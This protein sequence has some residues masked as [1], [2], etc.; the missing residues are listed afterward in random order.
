[1]A[2]YT[3]GRQKNLKVGLTSYSENKTSLEVVGKVGIGTTNATSSLYVVG[4]QFVTGV[5]TAS[6]FSGTATTATTAGS[7]KT[8]TDVIGGI[9]SVS[10]LFV[11]DIGISTLGTIKISS[12]II[13]ST[14]GTAATFFGN[15][16]GT[17]SSAGFAFTAFSLDSTA[18][19][20]ISVAYASTA[21]IATFAEKSGIS[22]HVI[23][24]IASVTQLNVTGI[25]TLGIVTSG[26][27]FS[28]GVVTATKFVGSLQGNADSATSATSAGSAG[29][30]ANATNLTGGGTASA[31]SLTINGNSTIS[32]ISTFGTGIKIDGTAGIITSINPG[33][34][35]VTYYGTLIGTAQ[36]DVTNV[37]NT[38]N[39]IGGIASVT[40]LFV[41]GIS[42]VGILTASRIG[43]GT[44]NPTTELWVGGNV[45]VTGISTFNN[46]RISSGIVS[47]TT[48]TAVTFFGDFVG[49]A[50]SAG[51]AQTAFTLNNRTESQFNVAYASTAGIATFATKSGVATDVI[52]GIASVTSLAVDLTGI[53]TLG[54]VKISSGIV[55]STTGTAVTFFGTFVGTASSA[56][57]AQT[58]FNLDSSASANIRVGFATTASNVIGG[59]ASVTDL[60]VSGFSTVGVLTA[61]MIGIGTT[62][63][64]AEL[65]VIGNSSISGIVTVGVGSTGIKID[66]TTGIITSSGVTTVTYFGNLTGTAS[67]ASFAQTAAT[68]GGNSVGDLRVGF[69]TTASNVVGGIASVTSLSVSGFSTVGVLTATRIGIGT[70][71][72]TAELFVFGNSVFDGTGIV[73][74]SKYNGDL[75]FG[76]P[77]APGFK[78][79]PVAITSTSSTRDSVN[80]INFILG[81]LVPKPPTTIAGVAL[82]VNTNAGTAL[83]C[84]SFTPVN[85]ATT[86]IVVPSAG[87][88]YKRN[89]SNTVSSATLTQY[90]P[91]DS[92]TV[93]ALLNNTV[94]VGTTT[95]STGSNNGTYG[96]LVISNDKDA[97]FSTRNTGI[98]S[99]FY[100]IYDAQISN[101]SGCPDG[102]NCISIRQ[103]TNETSKTT[104]LV[105]IWYEDG[106]TVSAP[107]L[108]AG[109]IV[110][111]STSNHQ[112]LYSSGVPHYSEDSA[113][114]FTYVLT[115]QN[116]SGDMYTSNTFCNGGSATSGFQASGNKTYTNFAGGTNPPA[117]NYGVGTGVTTLISQTPQ[118]TH[119]QLVSP[120]SFS[121]YTASTPYGTSSTPSVTLSQTINIMGS[122]ATTSKIDE[123]NISISSLGSG[124]S[125]NASRTNAGSGASTPS[126]IFTTW[127]ETV[128]VSTFEAT[129]VGGILKH[130]TTNYSTGFLPSE[131]GS[132]IAPNYSV[133]RSGSQYFQVKI[134]RDGVLSFKINVT[135][136]YAGCWV[137]L[138]NNST[139]MTS[140]AGA[141]NGWADMFKA[142]RGSGLP[143][144]SDSGCAIGTLM[145]GNDPTATEYTCTLAGQSS[146]AVGSLSGLILVRWR[147]NPGQSITA[148]QFYG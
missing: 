24:G 66:G 76:T 38:S 117:K 118:N 52:G 64:T 132:G 63:P 94:G 55:S 133:G 80:D 15:F 110:V 105:S 44:T 65:L 28:T 148:M 147:L 37:T 137:C 36:V 86:A 41:S 60:R 116:A 104:G 72:P 17:A 85:N 1:M 138:P 102:F 123:S 59:I 126:P 79:G 136:T 2:K 142:Y 131:G 109:T 125:S 145:D 78:S 6:S 25:T 47:S 67:T 46:V 128:G 40:Q 7:A 143:I 88:S 5:V 112:V 70:T 141:T 19:A 77:S 87:T 106:S 50:S 8:A 33:F 121:S 27:I 45:F 89:T 83:L 122:T 29:S 108:S 43:I 93:T 95:L 4:D 69:A 82:T 98:V 35:T 53:S 124:S 18:S 56:G 13:T 12:G 84:N 61:T 90:G 115:C 135:G 100:E 73:T 26:N 107:I 139:W 92:E 3:S 111:P 68:L 119:I 62:N 75:V 140:L 16:V 30:A 23:G 71:N 9:A 91:G 48:G 99:G 51:F 42:T 11:N 49:T 101:L 54:T 32:G 74:A 134:P 57:F 14:T 120:V 21:G 34:T 129:V 114:A 146:G 22:T 103:G 20:N 31:N 113:N 81:K 39:V 96:A 97:S 58:A 10:S 130:D 127:D 144:P